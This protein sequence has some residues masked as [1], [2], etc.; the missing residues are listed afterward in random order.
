MFLTA[1]HRTL[2]KLAEAIR[3]PRQ[4]SVRLR[5]RLQLEP[6]EDRCLLSYSIVDLGSL[7]PT[8]VN[9]AAQVA[10]SLNHY[11]VMEPFPNGRPAL[12]QNGTT[13]N[14]GGPG[15]T[16]GAAYDL[17]DS[18][19]VVGTAAVPGYGAFF[20][21]RA[22]GMSFG[23]LGLGASAAYGINASAQVVGTD[24]LNTT[25]PHG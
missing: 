9:A 5:A 20:W 6:L 17:N 11:G 10:G 19:Q 7:T 12:W 22:G 24:G 13:L 3:R 14:L 8:A 4:A 23:G 15:V 2:G 25:A 18:G 1:L 16:G 21:D